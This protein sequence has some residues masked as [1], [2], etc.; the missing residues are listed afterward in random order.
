MKIHTFGKSLVVSVLLTA[1]FILLMSLGMYK[2]RWGEG[3]MN[4]AIMAVYGIAVFVGGLLV[5][6]KLRNRR[7]VWGLLYGALYFAL[8][9]FLSWAVGGGIN[10]DWGQLAIVLGICLGS[11][12]AGGMIA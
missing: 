7:F 10:R 6:K 12:M 3:L 1:V 2:F 8:V 4:A 9:L 5:G 11:G